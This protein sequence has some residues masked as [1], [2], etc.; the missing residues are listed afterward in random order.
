MSRETASV[1]VTKAEF[2][3]AAAT[4]A[5]LPPPTTIEVV[6]AGR[7]NVGK[8][9]V[10]NTLMQRRNLAR[11]SSTPGCTRQIVFFG[12]EL[13][14]KSNLL[15]VDLP[16]Y[17]YA[18]RSKTEREGWAELIE[19]YLLRRPTLR[20]MMLLADVRRGL[21]Q[22]ELEL[23]KLMR[24]P[25]VDPNRPE[26]PVLIVATKV[27]KLSSIERSAHLKKLKQQTKE[28]VFGFSAVTGFGSDEV[29]RELRR[30]VF[31]SVPRPSD[32]NPGPRDDS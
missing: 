14:D 13:A 12:V 32:S 20:V 18:R 19:D 22:E 31:G 27:D 24:S 4:A 10:L 9:S 11:T 6:F 17:G 8:S 23:L 1:Q 7:S 2:L 15:F 30:R 29:W 16:G 28:P 3:A 25:E 26:V 21:E 5:Q